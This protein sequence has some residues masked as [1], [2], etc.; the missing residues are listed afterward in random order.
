MPK[1]NTV[2]LLNIVKNQ[3]TQTKNLGTALGGLGKL[4]TAN[5]KQQ[6][7]LGLVL[8]N[9]TAKYPDNTAI[10]FENQRYT[11][12][13]FNEW[14]NRFAHYFQSQGISKGDVVAIFLQNRPEVLACVAGLAKLGA[15]S[16]MLNTSQR[17]EVLIHSVN[18]VNPKLCVIGE[19]LV[20]PFDE[21]R[22]QINLDNNGTLLY[23]PDGSDT[24]TPSGYVDLNSGLENQPVNNLAVTKTIQLK[25]QCYYIFTSGTTG[26]P[27]ASVMSHFR[28]YSAMAGM[29]LSAMHFA[30]DDVFYCALPLYHNNALTIAWSTSIGAGGT[31]ALSRKFSVSRFWDD[32]R[33]YNATAFCY[34]GE[35][36]R[37]LLNQ[38]PSPKDKDH[39]VWT[40]TGN[41]LRPD[42]WMEFKERF[43]IDRIV[44]FYGSSEGNVAFSNAFNLDKTAGF[45]P[46]P[47]AIV[48]YDIDEDQPVRDA[49]NR[50]LKVHKGEAGL[51]L[52]EVTERYP[53]DGYTDPEA[54]EKK[55]Y[56][57]V[58]K[59]GDCWF[60]TGDLV[61]NQGYNHVAFVDRLGDTFR[62]KGENVATTE[63]EAAINSFTGV[64][65]AVVYG[66]EVPN[67][68][69]RAGMIA[70]TPENAADFNYTA[71]GQHL[72][73]TL[74]AY[75][76]PLFIRVRE[77]G[78]EV[79][80][81]FKHKKVDLKKAGFDADKVGE[82]LYVLLPKSD[83]YEP[84]TDSIKTQIDNG[85]VRL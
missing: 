4:L 13:Q 7:S 20:E 71:F 12:R 83:G 24:P 16:S 73:N 49:K 15:V 68:D 77:G 33:K 38:P 69:G 85:D 18:L 66:V 9:T 42:I 62:W 44:E 41:G 25:D 22:D 19:E 10:L 74:P 26:M 31:L 72:R 36:C 21:I 78:Q 45:C 84:L 8:E 76:V 70:L 35:L 57:N 29:G 40:I 6:K 61:R 2:S 17:G 63:V 43:G 11:Y 60:N 65:E 54:T 59:K 75:A 23:L 46:M 28:W 5:P 34:I 56:R 52:C 32:I 27:K 30:S 39:Q 58:F 51:L 80:G 48:Q 82:P 37:Y 79:T 55:L 64:E 14:A 67:T 81:T 47:F 3:L 1:E 50:M 53:F